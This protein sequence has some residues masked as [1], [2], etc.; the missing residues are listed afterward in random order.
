VSI[1]L[2]LFQIKACLLL[3]LI[4]FIFMLFLTP[5]HYRQIKVKERKERNEN[6]AEVRTPFL[7]CIVASIFV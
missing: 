1:S 7:L 4:P 3:Q 2:R 5:N 6:R